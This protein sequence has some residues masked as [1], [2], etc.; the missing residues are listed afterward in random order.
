[1]RI[2]RVVSLTVFLSFIVLA[3]TGI[4]LFV[5]PQGR[6]A[7]WSG[8]HLLGLSKVQYGELHTTFMVLFLAGG[9]W[10]IVLNWKSITNYLKNKSRHTRGKRVF[11]PEF[12]AA[13]ILMLLFLV[14]TLTGLPPFRT[15]LTAG[16]GIKSFWERH[17]GSPPWG[18]AEENSLARFTRGLVDWERVENQRHVEISVADAIEELRDAGFA[19]E[20]ERQKII[21]IAQ[22]R[23]TTPQEVMAVIL[24]AARP[25]DTAADPGDPAAEPPPTFPMPMSGLGRMTFQEYCQRYE[26][27]MEA[28]LSLLRKGGQTIDVEL[29]IKDEAER[30]GTDPA[31]LIDKL[32]ELASQ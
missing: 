1:M 20:S 15:F 4:M 7:Y 14:G 26:I 12:G 8:W 21:D 24:R 2:R 28:A 19:V 10:H 30:L 22:Q 6:V 29:R 16:E 9:I 32:N 13:L 3:Y 5:S 17:E 31:G 25:L 23:G 27:D 18:H 11:V